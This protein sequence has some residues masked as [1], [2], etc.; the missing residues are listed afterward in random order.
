MQAVDLRLKRF[1]DKAIEEYNKYRS[2][3]A[4]ARLER[5][6]GD[7]VVI[8]FEGPFCATCGINDWVEDMVFVMRDLGAEAELLEV[9]E[10]DELLPDEDWRVGVFRVRLPPHRQEEARRVAGVG[11]EG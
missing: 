5:I 2:P 4:T 6:E 9:I 7:V 3:E 1:V 8:R 11:V 10:P